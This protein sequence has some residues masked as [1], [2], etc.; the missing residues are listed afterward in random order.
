M[1]ACVL[2]FGA[3][4]FEWARRTLD[5]TES[6]R[7]FGDMPLWNAQGERAFLYLEIEKRILYFAFMHPNG[8]CLSKMKW[9]QQVKKDC[10]DDSACH[11][12]HCSLYCITL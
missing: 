5:G 11:H 9:N 7:C 3:L 1:P 12:H 4:F 2:L 10:K 8:I 6:K